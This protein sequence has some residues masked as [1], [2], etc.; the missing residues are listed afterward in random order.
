VLKKL[1]LAGHLT[2]QLIVK[3]SKIL[4]KEYK[5][6]FGLEKK[7]VI[8]NFKVLVKNK[9]ELIREKE[10]KKLYGTIHFVNIES[11]IVCGNHPRK[12]LE[13]QSLIFAFKFTNFIKNK[14]LQQYL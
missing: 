14:T 13:A 10:D 5:Y 8:E 1:I 6:I 3:K 4:D 12:I 11:S 9:K 2:K 7:E